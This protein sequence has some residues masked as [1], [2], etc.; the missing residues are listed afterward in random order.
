MGVEPEVSANRA[1]VSE[2]ANVEEPVSDVTAGSPVPEPPAAVEEEG[3]EEQFDAVAERLDRLEAQIAG[4][5]RRMDEL[6]RLGDRREDLVDRLHA[7]NQRLRVG[8]LAQAQA[9]VVR[10]LIR[11]FDLVVKLAGDSDD[12]GDLE[13]VRRRLLDGLEQVGVRPL[14]PEPGTAFDVSHET[15]VERTETEDQ[16]L[17]MTISRTLRVGFVQDGERT[18]RPAE[19][20]VRSFRSPPAEGAS[21]PVGSDGEE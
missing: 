10:E 12:R 14:E 21:G 5:T 18:L 1:D 2:H 9:P 19:V 6:V 4:V 3:A 15:A 11:T 20:V 7:D 8:E 17:D 13:L 16:A